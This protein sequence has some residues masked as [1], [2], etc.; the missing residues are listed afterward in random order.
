MMWIMRQCLI[1]LDPACLRS[2]SLSKLGY[3]YGI[4]GTPNRIC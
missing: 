4:H 3:N 1:A 2:E